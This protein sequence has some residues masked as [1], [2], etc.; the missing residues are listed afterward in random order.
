MPIRCGKISGEGAQQGPPEASRERVPSKG[1]NSR[2]TAY[3]PHPCSKPGLTKCEGVEC[4]DNAKGQR[5]DGICDKDGCDFNSYRMG[6]EGFYG[7]GAEFTVDTSRPFTVVTQF[8]TDDGTDTGDLV[9]VKRFYVQGGKIIPNSEATILGRKGGNSVTDSFCAAQKKKF[10]DPD[11]FTRQGALKQMGAALDRGMVLVL[12]LWDDS[13]VNMLWLD[14]AFPTDAPLRKPG[15]LRGPCPGGEQS[16]PE[17]LR[18]TYP[19][20]EVEF[21]LIKVGTINSTFTGGR[22]R[23]AEAFV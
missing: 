10:G 2:G 14:S 12:S 16:T 15:V 5:Y 22:R 11:D 9:E 19:D 20:A 3:T 6:A 1:R 8:L 23:L 21:S 17:Y 18:A 7:P 13:D 4:G